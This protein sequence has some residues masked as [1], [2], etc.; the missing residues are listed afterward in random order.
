MT[1]LLAAHPGDVIDDLRDYLAAV[2]SRLGVG[3]ESCCWGVEA[4]AWAYVALDWRLAGQDVALLWD[5]RTGWS[6]ATE[7]EIGC[8]MD[9]VARLDGEVAPEP[10][11]VARFVT[12]L[13]AEAPVLPAVSDR[14]EKVLT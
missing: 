5:S 10:A 4:P 6:V 14:D 2:T 12:A 9:V 8:D 1:K 3:L 11:V 13:R 7:P